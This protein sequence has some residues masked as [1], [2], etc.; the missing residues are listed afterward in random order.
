MDQH[1]GYVAPRNEGEVCR[2]AKS[3]YGLKL[4]PNNGMVSLIKQ[5]NRLAL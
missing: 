4:N 3:L 5:F 2:L 1:G